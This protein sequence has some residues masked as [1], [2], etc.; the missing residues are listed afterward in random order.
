MKLL[1]SAL[2]LLLALMLSLSTLVACKGDVP[3]ADV[4]DA[5]DPCANGHKPGAWAT[6]TEA[7]LTKEGLRQQVCSVCGAIIDS[8]TLDVLTVDPFADV[9]FSPHKTAVDLRE[10]TLVYPNNYNGSGFTAT[11]GNAVS[12]LATGISAVTGEEC[13]AYKYQNAPSSMSDPEI[14]VGVTEDPRSQ[15]LAASFNGHG[16]AVCVVENKILIQGTTNL[17]TIKAMQL[18]LQKYLAV[19]EVVETIE[20]NNTAKCENIAMTVIGDPSGMSYAIVRSDSLDDDPAAEYGATGGREFYDYPVDAANTMK[21]KFESLL[22]LSDDVIVVTTDASA[23]A[24]KEILLAYT[25]REDSANCLSLLA[26][27]E[28]GIF[29]YGENRI[30]LTAPSPAG[31]EYA[32]KRF[33]DYL[34]E[35]FC[36]N[37]DGS[38]AIMMPLDFAEIASDDDLPF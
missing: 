31:I 25:N 2:L 8:E 23:V 33:I 1:R 22:N 13:V 18:F 27:H 11:F 19:G 7:T 21:A 15:E 28:Y 12:A 6:V 34:S 26:G 4:E 38:I 37:D 17:L 10:Y 32:I 9:D 20:I 35:S 14:I 36:S 16:Y 24:D 3:D 5:G 30:V 29:L